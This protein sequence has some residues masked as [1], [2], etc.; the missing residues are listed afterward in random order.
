MIDELGL[1]GFRVGDAEVSTKHAG[2]IVNRGQATARDVLTLVSL[3]QQRVKEK[4]G[5]D[6]KTEFLIVGED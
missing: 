1:K 6:L 5:I 3:V 2:F 4:F